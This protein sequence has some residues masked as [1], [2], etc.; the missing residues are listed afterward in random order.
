MLEAWFMENM[1]AQGP[2]HVEIARAI[3]PYPLYANGVSFHATHTT[4]IV[5]YAPAPPSPPCGSCGRSDESRAAAAAVIELH[6]GELPRESK[7]ASSE[8]PWVR[9]ER[10]MR[11]ASAVLSPANP[12]EGFL[13]VGEGGAAASIQDL[14]PRVHLLTYR[15]GEG[16][17]HLARVPG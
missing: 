13:V 8:N 1:S 11:W 15:V 12:V 10:S 6:R 7:A 5:A 14:P 2:K 4:D 9:V 16:G 17:L 3:G